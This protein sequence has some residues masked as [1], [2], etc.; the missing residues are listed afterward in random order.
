[1]ITFGECVICFEDL[2]N[3]IGVLKCG[4]T[5]HF[6]CIRLW[7]TVVCFFPTIYVCSNFRKHMN[8]LFVD[9]NAN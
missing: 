6:D 8:A 2:L 1:M 3:N 7:I 4:H 5:F 9:A